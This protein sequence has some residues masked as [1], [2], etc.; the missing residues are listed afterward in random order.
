MSLQECGEKWIDVDGIR[1]RYF[2]AGS[3][4]TI[5]LVHGGTK[6]D[7]SGGAN[8]EDFHLNFVELAKDFRVISIDR[9]GQGYTDNPKRD[10]DYTMGA[11]VRHFVG[12][13]KALGG[14][15]FNVMGHSRGGYVVARTTLDYPRL[16]ESCTLIDSNTAS[17]GPGRNELVFALN[18]YKP[19]TLE[20]S[21]W[22][23]EKYS[24]TTQHVT[25]AWIEL[26]QKITD[27]PK[28]KTAIAKMK[29]EGLLATRFLP[30]L[31]EDK[32]E[33]FSKLKQIGMQRPIMLFWGFNDP[34]APL[35]DGMELYDIIAAKQPRTSMHIVNQAGHHS[36]RER[37]AEFNRVVAE[38]VE[39]VG[40]GE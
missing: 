14:G 22:V 35:T 32:D 9:L 23:Y 5:V 11:A 19:G 2:E 1:T 39:G 16:I 26:K 3:G 18:P 21:R 25:D 24:C 10:E 20:S 37:A 38:F 33:F 28:N 30:E 12:F 4:R 34:T 17:P 27:L 15:P 13:L 40:R 31:L 7:A 8:A 36:F 29:D 6:G